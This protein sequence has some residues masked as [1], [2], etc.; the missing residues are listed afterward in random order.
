MELFVLRNNKQRE[1][2][3]DSHLKGHRLPFKVLTQ[4]IYPDRS[5]DQ[6][7]Y[8]FGVVYKYIEDYT[9]MTKRE[10]HDFYKN[11][12]NI[13]YSPDRYGHW[14]LRHK[15]STEF[16]TVEMEQFAMMVR[17]HAMIELGI[18]IPLPNECVIDKLDMAVSGR[19]LRYA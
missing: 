7:A 14:H 16:D 11:E 9:G 10:V 17:A 19:V 3:I 8:L 18:N 13:E 1:S 5:L 15:S 6:N 12:F 2:L 4:E